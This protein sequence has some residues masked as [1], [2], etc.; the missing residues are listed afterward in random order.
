MNAPHPSGPAPLVLA[1][2][3]TLGQERAALE[4]L[5]EAFRR[6]L[7][8][9]R[10]GDPTA[11]EHATEDAADAIATL[12]RVGTARDRQA[13]LLGRVLGLAD[14]PLAALVD[15]LDAPEADWL[16]AAHAAVRDEAAEVRSRAAALDFALRHA[17]HLGQA[18]IRAMQAPAGPRLYD[19]SGQAAPG[20]GRRA[21]V[22][23]VG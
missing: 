17:A 14:A 15:A 3:E 4:T 10:R 19:A 13:R 12:G 16:A 21:L 6:Q 22:N 7:A 8:A 11:H 23:R 18:L 2:A 5:A 1:L 20:G 9:L